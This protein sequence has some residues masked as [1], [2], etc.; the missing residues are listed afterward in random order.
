MYVPFPLV[1]Q[2]AIAISNIAPN[3]AIAQFIVATVGDGD[4]GKRKKTVVTQ[5]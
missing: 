1:N 2:K 4:P 3:T 5:Q